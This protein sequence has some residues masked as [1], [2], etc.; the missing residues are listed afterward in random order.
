M[1]VCHHWSVNL[2][3]VEDQVV[4]SARRW[5]DPPVLDPVHDGLKR[6]VQIDHNVHRGLLL[7]GLCLC[8]GPEKKFQVTIFGNFVMRSPPTSASNLDHYLGNPSKS[9]GSA[10]SF[11]SSP[12]TRPTITESGTKSP[13]AMKAFASRPR[14]VP[15][16]LSSRISN[17]Y[18]AFVNHT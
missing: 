12:A 3:W 15:S 4:D 13:F 16:L 17:Y 5:V 6:H 18:M 11:L 8:L 9:Q 14:G 7:Q 10:S 2:G 1:C